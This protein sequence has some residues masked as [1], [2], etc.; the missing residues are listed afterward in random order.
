MVVRDCYKIVLDLIV[1][2]LGCNYKFNFDTRTYPDSL[3]SIFQYLRSDLL[4]EFNINV[5]EKC[6]ELNSNPTTINIFTQLSHTFEKICFIRSIYICLKFIIIIVIVS[7][8]MAHENVVYLYMISWLNTIYIFMLH[9]RDIYL[10]W[11][12]SFFILHAWLSLVRSSGT[13]NT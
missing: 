5:D 11:I 9:S 2:E 6:Y 3:L 8:F 1:Q 10:H 4:K 12:L 13:A 7:I